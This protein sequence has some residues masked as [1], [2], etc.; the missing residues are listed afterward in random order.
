M[1]GRFVKR[2]ERKQSRKGELMPFTEKKLRLIE[3]ETR[4]C[5]RIIHPRQGAI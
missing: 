5:R 1:G 4:N 3:G 2:F